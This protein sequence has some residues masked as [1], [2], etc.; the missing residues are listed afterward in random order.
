[1][2]E[3]EYVCD[4]GLT[5]SIEIE[6]DEKG[7]KAEIERADTGDVRR[8]ATADSKL[9]QASHPARDQMEA[10]LDLVDALDMLK[11]N[12][13]RVEYLS[14]N[15]PDY[16]G[17]IPLWNDR[18]FGAQVFTEIHNYLASAYTFQETFDTVIQTLPSGEIV[19]SKF[20]E[21]KK[22]TQVVIGLRTYVQ[23]EQMFA[24]SHPPDLDADDYRIDFRVRLDEVWTMESQI[25]EDNPD[26]Y[27]DDPE[28]IYG[29]VD[30]EYIDILSQF[31][32]HLEA[33]KDLVGTVNEYVD[34][35][36]GDELDEFRRLSDPRPDN[37]E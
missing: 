21:F 24:V 28:E 11:V 15:Q 7:M 10:L 23:H 8:I 29:P 16:A 2:F 25:C 35:E 3:T 26:G 27:D 31:E 30:G 18:R 33:A 22:E 5:Y 36:M 6:E 12:W 37:D 4:C 9:Y 32:Q 34:K 19:D 13:S 14:E 1:M 17:D 20:Q